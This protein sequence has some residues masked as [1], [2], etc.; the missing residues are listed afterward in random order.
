MPSAVSRN[1]E[2]RVV[3]SGHKNRPS[4]SS[5]TEGSWHPRLGA[6]MASELRRQRTGRGG[7]SGYSDPRELAAIE[8]VLPSVD[9]RIPLLDEDG[10]FMWGESGVEYAFRG[11]Y[12]PS[13]L[14]LCQH[15]SGQALAGTIIRPKPTGGWGIAKGCP[16]K[17]A[18]W[19]TASLC[20]SHPF[21]IPQPPALL[22]G[23]GPGLQ[24]LAET[25]IVLLSYGSHENTKSGGPD[26]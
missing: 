3:R 15:S 5:T 17:T 9:A 12:R 13:G 11:T 16:R 7:E 2:P 14:T 6:V 22:I 25:R 26:G 24:G 21:A 10:I 19:G 20:P 8:G 1:L 23:H 18:L 4:F